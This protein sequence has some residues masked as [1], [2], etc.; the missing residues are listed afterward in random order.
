MSLVATG[1]QDIMNSWDDF[2]DNIS[3]AVK[4]GIDDGLAPIASAMR[5]NTTMMFNKGYMEGVMVESVSHTATIGDDNGVY[6]SVGVYDMSRKTGSADRRLPAPELAYMYEHGIRPHSTVAGVKLE[7]LPTEKS[8]R[9]KAA[10]GKQGRMMH[11]GSPPI[12]FLSSAWDAN[13]QKI[14]PTLLNAMKKE[15]DKL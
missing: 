6:G 12:P 9:G 13:N 7:Q 11:Q 5:S 1:F 8:P 3:D 4:E 14:T 15:T 10:V 2:A